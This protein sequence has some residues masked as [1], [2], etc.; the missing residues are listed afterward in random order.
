MRRKLRTS[1]DIVACSTDADED[2]HKMSKV[3]PYLAEEEIE[4]DALA[5]L[6]EYAQARGI[7]IAPPI[8]I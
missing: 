6:A 7:V 1:D 3:V 2:D 4:A 5:L 8:P